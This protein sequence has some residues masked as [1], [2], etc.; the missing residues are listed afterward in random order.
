[1]GK[2]TIAAAMT[3]T[4]MVLSASDP[5]SAEPRASD[6]NI[7]ARVLSGE[8]LTPEQALYAQIDRLGTVK[9][10]LDKYKNDGLTE[11]QDKAYEQLFN[12]GLRL[13]EQV[14]GQTGHDVQVVRG[15]FVRSYGSVKSAYGGFD[16][17]TYAGDAGSAAPEYVRVCEA[18]GSGYFYI[19]GTETCLRIT[20]NVRPG[21]SWIEN[22]HQLGGGTVVTNGGGDGNEN[23]AARFG[24]WIRRD[25]VSLDFRTSGDYGGASLGKFPIVGI[26]G[27][28]EGAWG[29]ADYAGD[30][31]V[32]YDGVTGVGYTYFEPAP[33]TGAIAGS[34]GFGI[35][36]Q[37]HLDNSWNR[38]N[39]G[40]KIALP[41]GGD[42]D[43]GPR[44]RGRL[45]VFYEDL[46]TSASGDTQLTYNGSPYAGYS[47]QWDLDAKDRY[48][49]IRT[50]VHI[51]FKPQLD[52][53]LKTSIGGDLYL[54]YHS[55]EGSYYQYSQAGGAPI[56]QIVDY[57]KN[58]FSIGGALTASATYEFA[59]GW[60]LGGEA[61]FS[62]L[63]G[64][65][66][67]L[68]PQ[69]PNEQADAGFFS[70]RA[71]RLFLRGRI[72]RSF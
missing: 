67:F 1:M 11:G 32:G 40:L 68:A 47:Q 41:V 72:S 23:F 22:T 13:S 57:S 33:S 9:R 4:T 5:A 19:P 52:G 26:Y 12:E 2:T 25:G 39:F 71:T 61:E 20:G 18:I 53:K 37:G 14:A 44:V 56:T 7:L 45:G 70:E 51:G 35:E 10:E 31:R 24:D 15:A 29:D 34:A 21:V 3:A 42:G 43:T 27:G 38:A 58:G 48:Y 63:P 69:N 66:S 30:A 28:Y 64:V 36:T 55:G 16:A 6:L 49:G 65:T 8:G 60:R 62:C 50:G 17:W 46:K 59:P 54:G